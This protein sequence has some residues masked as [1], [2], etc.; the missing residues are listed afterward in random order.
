M[1]ELGLAAFYLAQLRFP[2]HAM[3]VA[4]T[5]AHVAFL[6]PQGITRAMD[7]IAE[8]WLFGRKTPNLSFTR[9][10]DEL[11]TPLIDLRERFGI[12]TAAAAV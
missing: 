10:E 11:D 12:E 7:A 4:V 1:G 6:S 2:Y 8:G 3:R 5:T 9:W